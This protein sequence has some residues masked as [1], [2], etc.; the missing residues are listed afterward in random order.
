VRRVLV[1]NAD[2]FG[3]T[4]AIN[5]GIVEAAE[6]GI[7]T[8]ASLMV[9]WPA[10]GEAAELAGHL[11]GFGL[12]LHVDLGEWTYRTGEWRAVYELEP[13][14]AEL[15]LQLDEFRRLAGRNPDHLDS[16]QH[17][18]RRSP[19]RELL[20]E[21]GRELEVPV[22]HFSSVH[23]EG[24]FY[25]RGRK[26]EP[27]PQAISVGRLLEILSGLPAGATELVCHPGYAN[28]LDSSYRLERERELEALCDPRVKE[29]LKDEGIDL[30]PW[31][32][33]FEAA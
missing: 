6:R 1:V 21:L 31:S 25:G 15:R 13:T 27:L 26:G 18:H 19:S 22:R 5:R 11:S 9:R 29:L 2:D 28:G 17:V 4:P 24:S 12:G 23:V 3:R 8:A 16:H 32:Q 33:I 30:R 14:A 7:V 10:A 20:V